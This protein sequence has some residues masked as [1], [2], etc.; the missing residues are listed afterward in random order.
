[1]TRHSSAAL[2]A[3]CINRALTLCVRYGGET[4][5]DRSDIDAIVD[6][7][8]CHD[9]DLYEYITNLPE[10]DYLNIFGE[11]VSSLYFGNEEIDLRPYTD[12]NMTLLVEWAAEHLADETDL[13][14]C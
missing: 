4:L 14:G 1:M 10:T 2:L 7:V 8:R 3:H 6:V 11:T 5:T 12:S 13:D 9:N